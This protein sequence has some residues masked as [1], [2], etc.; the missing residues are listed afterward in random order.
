MDENRQEP[1]EW[2]SLFENKTEILITDIEKVQG[3]VTDTNS[4][5]E[6]NNEQW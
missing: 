1:K 5:I 6:M 2:S 4:K 3:W